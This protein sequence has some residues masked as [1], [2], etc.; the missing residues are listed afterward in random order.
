MFFK[1]SFVQKFNFLLFSKEIV[2]QYNINNFWGDHKMEG[3]I[4]AMEY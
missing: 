4:P 2:L 1:Q 3:F